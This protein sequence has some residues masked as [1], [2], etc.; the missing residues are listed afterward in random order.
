[1]SLGQPTKAYLMYNV[2]DIIVL[3]LKDPT[4]TEI[5]SLETAWP[6]PGEYLW[7]SYK[8]QNN[9]RTITFMSHTLIS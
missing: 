6:S 2:P 4:T 3:F 1:M 7:K 5:R 9:Q 8:Q